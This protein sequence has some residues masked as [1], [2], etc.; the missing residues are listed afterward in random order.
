[1][2]G[3]RLSLCP[4]LLWYWELLR[5]LQS[6]AA[7]KKTWGLGWLTVGAVRSLPPG[8]AWRKKVAAKQL[9]RKKELLQRLQSAPEAEMA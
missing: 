6:A 4:G 1:M 9:L 2:G 3:Q 5:R 7:A 8:V